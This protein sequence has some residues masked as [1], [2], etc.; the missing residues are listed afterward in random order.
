ML[1]GI[2]GGAL[3]AKH[4]MQD[5][6]YLVVAPLLE[7]RNHY[8]SLGHD[9]SLFVPSLWCDN[10]QNATKPKL[11][12]EPR[13]ARLKELMANGTVLREPSSSEFSTAVADEPP[14]V[15]WAIKH[16][17]VLV[18]TRG[19]LRQDALHARQSEH[20][21][22]HMREWL[23]GWVCGGAFAFPRGA[24]EQR[25]A[26]TK[27]F[28]MPTGRTW[29]HDV[30]MANLA[31]DAADAEREIDAQLNAIELPA[32]AV[33]RRRQLER[34]ERIV[35]DLAPDGDDRRHHQA[36]KVV[37]DVINKW[38]F[39]AK[40][41]YI[42]TSQAA[43]PAEEKRVDPS[44]GKAYTCAEFV[45]E[46]GGTAE[47]AAAIP[48]QAPPPAEPMIPTTDDAEVETLVANAIE[49]A[50]TTRSTGGI[51]GRRW[52]TCALARGS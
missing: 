47:W 46:Y 15:T 43:P 23:A 25:W 10:A 5:A 18:S 44:D 49:T 26:P 8:L 36:K 24:A 27:T 13:L 28:A 21:K 40:A 19:T 16:T 11:K 48:L 29:A 38:F 42:C 6:G 9:V 2:D 20:Q 7:V 1:I 14:L 32:V 34:L 37:G 4:T 41:P 35:A 50:T 3:A 17:A 51:A 33:C 12:S 22:R 39:A 30:L 45:E 52:R 31:P